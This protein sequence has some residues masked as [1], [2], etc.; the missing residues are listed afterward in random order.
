[1]SPWLVGLDWEWEGVGCL[2]GQLR[3][4]LSFFSKLKHSDYILAYFSMNLTHKNAFRILALAYCI[5]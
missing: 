2:F 3:W 5:I 4:G 1:M